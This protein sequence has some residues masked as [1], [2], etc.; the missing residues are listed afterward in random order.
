[1]NFHRSLEKLVYP[2]SLLQT[3]SVR[4]AFLTTL[5]SQ[6]IIWDLLKTTM[7]RANNRHLVP[8]VL[9]IYLAVVILAVMSVLC[10]LD[11]F[12]RATKL[13][14]QRGL[15]SFASY[16]LTKLIPY[17]P[18]APFAAQVITRGLLEVAV[19]RTSYHDRLGVTNINRPLVRIP[20]FMNRRCLCYKCLQCLSAFLGTKISAAIG[21]PPLIQVLVRRLQELAMFA[22]SDNHLL[23]RTDILCLAVVVL[24]PMNLSRH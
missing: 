21:T 12:F 11:K 23:T 7:Y 17:A 14:Q 6:V 2:K 4:A 10:Q 24:I 5:P 13:L 1:M 15:V 3:S 8:V 9:V 20:A 18:D 19:Y 22:A 16:F